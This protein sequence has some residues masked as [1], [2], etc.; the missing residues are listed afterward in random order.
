MPVE[1]LPFGVGRINALDVFNRLL[2]K[3]I[4]PSGWKPNTHLNIQRHQVQSRREQWPTAALGES[5]PGHGSTTGKDYDCPIIVAE[6]EGKQRLL[7]GAHRINRWIATG[8][9]R[10]HDVNVHT[11]IG[12]GQFIEVPTAAKGA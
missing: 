8:D 5:P 6:Y 12:V 2:A 3:T 1:S 11:I 7:D 9:T 10:V 4:K